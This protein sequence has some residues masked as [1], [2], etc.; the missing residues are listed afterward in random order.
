MV[1]ELVAEGPDDFHVIA[2]L[3][4]HHNVPE[5]FDFKKRD[6]K[7]GGV[8]FLLDELKIRLRRPD[9]TRFGLVVD[10]DWDLDARWQSLRDRFRNINPT[11]DLPD[12]PAAGGLVQDFP[13]NR[14]IGIWLMPDN[15]LSG[16]LESF[17]RQLVPTGDE[18]LPLVESFVDG[19][20]ATARRF[21][22]ERR[23]K[24]IIHS[25]LG[26]QSEPGK[27]LGQAITA[28][29]LDPASPIA[30]EFVAWIRRLF[31]EP[32]H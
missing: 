4:A 31:V 32:T 3:L 12:K 19:L 17:A 8:E 22:T 1:A 15:T 9:L 10:A 27:P 28:R 13:D 18:L 6:S 24:A 29:Y 11:Y 26:L 7:S 20:P 30:T 23:P 25:W 14:R 21:P 16:M 2:T 5:S